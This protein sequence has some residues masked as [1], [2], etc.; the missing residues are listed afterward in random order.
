MHKCGIKM[1]RVPASGFDKKS[2]EEYSDILFT[3]LEVFRPD[4]V[5][6]VTHVLKARFDQY[7]KIVAFCNKKSIPVVARNPHS[8]TFLLI[9]RRTLANNKNISGLLATKDLINWLKVSYLI[10]KG[11]L[12]F[13]KE[14][15]KFFIKRN[16]LK[17]SDL[18]IVQTERDIVGL[19]SKFSLVRE[20]IV[21]LPK[22][23][24][25]KVF[26]YIPR[27]VAAK[28]LGLPLN[29]NYLLHVSNLVNR[30]GC[31]FIINVLS[32][33]RQKFPDTK[34]LITGNGEERKWIE[35]LSKD[36]GF[37]NVVIFSGH[38]DHDKLVFY[39]NIADVMILPS[40]LEVEGQPN[41]ILEAL[42]CKTIVITT[43]LPG[44]TAV[45]KN[46]L[47]ILVEPGNEKVL[48][49]AI[50]NVLSG[51][52]RFDEGAYNLFLSEYSF[53]NLG[54]NIFIVFSEIIKRR[55]IK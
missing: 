47:G 26:H 23:V 35:K 33:I 5:F 14:V 53:E 27:E 15:K 55:T 39:Y 28:N 6:S 43:N 32:S 17:K 7:D 46:G 31:D 19:T 48:T 10:I 54:R 50:I 3:E 1:V 2:G 38:V 52:F 22:P 16:S 9:F 25:Q 12:L 51:N 45:V 20:K 36:K 29:V 8:D 24:D 34:L 41:A 49:D 37:D 21:I 11:V 18:I 30:K 4:I 40:D 13:S 44:P 42:A